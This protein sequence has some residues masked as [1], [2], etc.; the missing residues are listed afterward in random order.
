[1]QLNRANRWRSVAEFKHALLF[2]SQKHVTTMPEKRQEPRAVVQPAQPLARTIPLETAAPV[3]I[4]QRRSRL[5]IG[6]LGGLLLVVLVMSWLV[7]WGLSPLLA[8]G[9]RTPTPEIRQPTEFLSANHTETATAEI[10]ATLNPVAQTEAP[11]P[12]ASPLSASITDAKGVPMALIPSGEFLMGSNNISDDEKLV[13]TVYLDAFY[14]DIY[15]VTNSRYAGC[16]SAGVCQPPFLSRSSK[17]GSYYGDL[18]YSEYPVIFINWNMANTYCEGRGASL[19][20]EAQWEKAARGGLQGMD[21]PWGNDQPVCDKKAQNGAN[22]Y[23]CATKDTEPVAA[24][25]RTVTDCSIWREMCG[26][27]SMT[28]TSRIIMPIHPATTRSV[29]ALETTRRFAGAVGTSKRST[30]AWRTAAAKYRTST[31]MN[32]VSV[33][34]FPH[35]NKFLVSNIKG[36]YLQLWATLYA[37]SIIR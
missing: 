11:A 15:E 1:M 29:R 6:R 7:M 33:A 21:Y 12:K 17:R 16:V 37:P 32:S 25:A 35:G 24:T 34:L 36:L 27:G 9:S 18:Q 4:P 22:F 3:N 14:L 13:H 8:G 30:C 26:S 2:L 23:G 31:P 10:K 19:P 20:T 5:L 28:G